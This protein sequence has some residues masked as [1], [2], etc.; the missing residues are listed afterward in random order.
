M[1]YP[2]QSRNPRGVLDIVGCPI[3]YDH[4][5][6]SDWHER[7]ATSTELETVKNTVRTDTT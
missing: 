7:G 5:A 2:V 1:G 6:D 4:L 3:K